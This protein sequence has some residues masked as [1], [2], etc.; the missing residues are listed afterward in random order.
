LP[1]LRL[2]IERQHERQHVARM[3]AATCGRLVV[4]PEFRC[5]HPGYARY[6]SALLLKL[7]N[8]ASLGLIA[9]VMSWVAPSICAPAKQGVEL[10]RS[11]NILRDHPPGIEMV[12]KTWE[13]QNDARSRFVI[14]LYS[15]AK[16]TDEVGGQYNEEVLAFAQGVRTDFAIW[17]APDCSLSQTAIYRAPS[18]SGPHLIVVTAEPVESRG[19]EIVPQSEPRPQRLR[20]FVPKL[21][22]IDEQPGKS[23][24][25]LDSIKEQ[26]TTESLCDAQ[27]IRRAMD[28]FA[29]EQ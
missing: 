22:G 8:L 19:A 15:K 10:A 24:T 18:P 14:K 25:W 29:A 9:L 13:N 11:I 26:V 2:P 20:L 28:A 7:V 3:S 27:A 4:S 23:S 17:M 5:A 12:L 16:T 1:T 6:I 21:N